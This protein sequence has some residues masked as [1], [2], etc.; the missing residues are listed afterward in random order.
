MQTSQ[1]FYKTFANLYKQVTHTLHF[2]PTK[3]LQHFTTLYKHKYKTLQTIKNR[4]FY[5]TFQHLHLLQ[6]SKNYTT[7]YIILPNG[8]K[9]YKTIRTLQKTQLFKYVQHFYTTFT[10]LYRT[11]ESFSKHPAHSNN[12]QNFYN[13]CTALYTTSQ[14]STQN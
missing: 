6:N 7:L 12:I 5:N 3:T 10:K 11:P 2:F 1:D 13:Y 14:N 9:L 8:Q 4:K